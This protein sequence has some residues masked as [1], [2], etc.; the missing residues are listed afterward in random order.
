MRRE[1]S[2]ILVRRLAGALR[3]KHW[4]L[5]SK[6]VQLEIDVNESSTGQ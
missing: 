4:M 6:F 2:C 3:R 5:K 1:V